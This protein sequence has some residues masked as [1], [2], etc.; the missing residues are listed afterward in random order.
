MRER[1]ADGCKEGGK[2]STR[3]EG[4]KESTC[5]EVC[6]EGSKEE[7]VVVPTK[8][9]GPRLVRGPFLFVCGSRSEWFFRSCD[10][11]PTAEGVKRH[12]N[13]GSTT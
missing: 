7:E 6:E 3:K 2:E 1:R 12:K 5:Q 13:E 4:R 9:K 10:G 8:T 11:L